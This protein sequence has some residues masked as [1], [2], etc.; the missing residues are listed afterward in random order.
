LR[1]FLVDDS[2][3]VHAGLQHILAGQPDIELSGYAGDSATALQSCADATLD[4]MIISSLCRSIDVLQVIQRRAGLHKSGAG[5]VLLLAH[6]I[7]DAVCVGAERLGVGGIVLT[8]ESPVILLAALRVV[9]RGYA[10]SAPGHRSPRG[11]H[12]ESAARTARDPALSRELLD[13]LTSREREVLTIMAR[14]LKNCE[15]AEE[16]LVSEST[17]KTH[18]QNLLTKLGLRNRASAVAVAYEM[19]LTRAASPCAAARSAIKP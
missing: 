6:D 8:S 16:L 1:V 15:I 5:Q 7:G 10:V 9:S 11:D 19:G 2:T 4:V 18:V 3:L 17:V 13:R 14:G 12:E